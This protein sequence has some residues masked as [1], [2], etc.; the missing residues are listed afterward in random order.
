MWVADNENFFP[1]CEHEVTPNTYMRYLRNNP[2][3]FNYKLNYKIKI[4][5]IVMNDYI[6]H[7]ICKYNYE[8]YSW[9]ND[10]YQYGLFGWDGHFKEEKPIKNEALSKLKFNSI[11]VSD[12]YCCGLDINGSLY[13][14]GEYFAI[15][16]LI[17]I[18][19]NDYHIKKVSCGK[20]IIAYVNDLDG[21]VLYNN[22]THTKYSVSCCWDIKDIACGVSSVCVVC[23]KGVVVINCK[24]VSVLKL[25]CSDDVVNVN[26]IGNYIYLITQ[27]KEGNGV[28]IL[29]HIGSNC[30]EYN[31]MKY[32]KCNLERSVRMIK[33]AYYNEGLFFEIDCDEKMKNEIICGKQKV[34]KFMKSM[35]PVFEMINDNKKGGI[36]YEEVFNK[37][38]VGGKRRKTS[39]SWDVNRRKRDKC[40]KRD[41]NCLDKNVHSMNIRNI[42]SE[43]LEKNGSEKEINE[44]K[45]KKEDVKEQKVNV[46]NDKIK[47]SLCNEEMMVCDDKKEIYEDVKGK[48]EVI[49]EEEIVIENDLGKQN[50]IDI[51]NALNN[52]VIRN[53]KVNSVVVIE[54][55]NNRTKYNEN[56]FESSKYE[57]LS[58]IMEQIN[59]MENENSQS[60]DTSIHNNSSKRKLSLKQP[61]SSIPIQGTEL[62]NILSS[63]IVNNNNNNHI[64]LSSNKNDV[65]VSNEPNNVKEV[66]NSNTILSKEITNINENNKEIC[67]E[68]N[69]SNHSNI[70]NNKSKDENENIIIINNNNDDICKPKE[71]ENS[72]SV[73]EIH[74]DNELKSSEKNTI[75]NVVHQHNNEIINKENYDTNINKHT[76]LPN[77]ITNNTSPSNQTQQPK[78]NNNNTTN[79][80][81]HSLV[82]SSSPV[83]QTTSNTKPTNKPVISN[84]KTTKFPNKKKVNNNP[85][86][87]LKSSNVI[88]STHTSNPT[89]TS[90]L[91]KTKFIPIQPPHHHHNNPSNKPTHNRS[92]TILLATP[93]TKTHPNKSLNHNKQ[94][95]LSNPTISP[96]NTIKLKTLNDL[97]TIINSS[98]ETNSDSIY[99]I[100]EDTDNS[101]LTN[102]E[103]ESPS[104]PTPTLTTVIKVKNNKI[105]NQIHHKQSSHIKH[106]SILP[107][108]ST[109][110]HHSPS[111]QSNTSHFKKQLHSFS[112]KKKHYSRIEMWL[113]RTRANLC[114]KT[115]PKERTFNDYYHLSSTLTSSH[116]QTK[117]SRNFTNIYP[118]HN[119]YHT[120]NSFGLIMS[121]KNKTIPTQHKTPSHYVSQTKTFFTVN[122]TSPSVRCY[123]NNNSN[124]NSTCN[125]HRTPMKHKRKCIHEY[126]DI[127]NGSVFYHSKTTT[128]NNQMLSLND[129]DDINNN[130]K[131]DTLQPIEL[132]QSNNYNTL[133]SKGCSFL[134]Y[135]N[136]TYHHSKKV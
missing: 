5:Q 136:K 50:D 114:L 64:N 55:Y 66:D 73:K 106:K 69:L 72:T 110:H 104:K 116:Q 24:G 71:K 82:S 45:E 29:K 129:D 60:Q 85:K 77:N 58:E 119:R 46:S 39:F 132:D 36:D 117:H 27:G 111:F 115:P 62:N 108:S 105:I 37:D 101:S 128:S 97:L 120:I 76:N 74:V 70:I 63:Q 42:C 4:K 86:I 22:K 92:N 112:P 34:F 33:T 107:H 127:R 26:I 40:C 94:H 109:H 52:I 75:I 21:V 83:I 93:P 125:S 16:E 44:V 20:Y 25:K 88:Q 10:I 53:N 135:T 90:P 113:R 102:I 89:P 131:N 80:N 68:D 57:S 3:T 54:N 78:S 47:D 31:Y 30:E 124:S 91:S 12:T 19:R 61:M 130:N 51:N 99:Y 2:L 84:T 13:G 122:N 49:K 100:I 32:Y 121:I 118:N 9:G 17:N 95:S 126:N 87:N 81:T 103:E 133:Q 6:V 11:E 15:N 7:C 48:D 41:M 1:Q 67:N 23:G 43:K 8:V 56:S 18:N 123:S 96:N 14:W 65:Q 79:S 98:P 35:K 38:D 28:I 59:E 134:S